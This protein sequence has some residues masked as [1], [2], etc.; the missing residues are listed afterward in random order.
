M[1]SLIGITLALLAACCLAGQALT[2][3]VATQNGRPTDVLLVV[4]ADNI[5]ILVPLTAMVDPNPTLTVR[6]IVAFFVL[7]EIVTVG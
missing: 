4:M 6:S 1:V 3:R 2:I 5:V 7:D